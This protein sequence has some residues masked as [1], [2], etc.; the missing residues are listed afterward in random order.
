MQKNAVHLASQNHVFKCN[1]HLQKRKKRTNQLK[2]RYL[3]ETP[4][5][6]HVN[7]I[8]LEGINIF[9]MCSFVSIVS[10]RYVS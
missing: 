9:V 6:L 4:I 10:A 2:K 8:S 5:S 1:Q 7:T 3:Q